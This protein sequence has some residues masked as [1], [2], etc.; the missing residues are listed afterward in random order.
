MNKV[1]DS[2]IDWVISLGIFLLYL[3]WFFIFI[4]PALFQEEASDFTSFIK[5]NFDRDT[6]WVVEK[7]PIIIHSEKN[8]QKEPIIV[9]I[10]SNYNETN[11]FM[12]N[13]SFIIESNKLMFIGD[14][15]LSS[16]FY[17][18]SSNETYM[19]FNEVTDLKATQNSASVTDFSVDFNN[20]MLHSASFYGLKIRDALFKIDGQDIDTSDSYFSDKKIAAQYLIKSQAV[21]IS[22]Y[23]F[24]YN[25]RVYMFFYTDK[26]ISQKFEI[27]NYQ[28]YF[29]D[30]KDKGQI[31]YPEACYE[32]NTDKLALYDNNSVIFFFFNKKVNFYFCSKND[33]LELKIEFNGSSEQKIVFF[34]GDFDE[35]IDYSGV[36]N[37]EVGIK[38]ETKLYSIQKI[39]S[40]SSTDYTSL[41][42][43]WDLENFRI[44]VKNLTNNNVIA[45]IGTSPYD[46]ADIYAEEITTFSV[47]KFSDIEEIKIIFQSW[48]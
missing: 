11:S 3:A 20:F 15:N 18:I 43:K 24:A 9:N 36:Y 35:Y 21:N 23:V 45:E 10:S 12:E 31:H 28:N 39:Q 41:K 2:Q 48:R 37:A 13:K 16:V 33:T 5:E 38:E 29:F 47:D 6:M 8:L 27:D 7:V 34:K 44:I 46:S 42:N 4:K 14:V 19:M 32:K 30:N 22:T 1:G 40:L 25:P 26:T 17:L